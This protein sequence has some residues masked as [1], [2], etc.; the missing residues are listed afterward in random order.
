VQEGQKSGQSQNDLPRFENEIGRSILINKLADVTALLI[1]RAKTFH[2][3]IVAVNAI[4]HC[5]HHPREFVAGVVEM[6]V[7]DELVRSLVDEDLRAFEHPLSPE[8]LRIGKCDLAEQLPVH[9]IARGIAAHVALVRI[10][11]LR[12]VF[13][14]PV[15][16]PFPVSDAA[17]MG[18]NLLA[19]VIEPY[20]AGPDDATRRE[21]RESG[22]E[23]EK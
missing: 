3:T 12:A 10:V 17:A 1:E 4:A 13:A 7:Q 18:L 2:V 15:V 19:T 16:G 6:R 23:C 5:D 8:I 21:G 14:K 22:R 11:G 20:I 9:Q